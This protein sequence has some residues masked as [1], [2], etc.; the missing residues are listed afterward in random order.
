MKHLKKSKNQIA[1]Q[2]KAGKKISP[3]KKDRNQFIEDKTKNP[4]SLE[5]L[6]EQ[7]LE[8]SYDDFAFYGDNHI[9]R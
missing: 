8:I 3:K 2:K 4:F 5:E 6:D 7:S 1:A 9:K